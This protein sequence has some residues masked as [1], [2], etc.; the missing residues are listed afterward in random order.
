[1]ARLFLKGIDL[2]NQRAV[3]LADG[4][5]ATDAVT[6][7]QLQAMVRGLSWKDEVKGASTTNLTVASALVNGLVHDGVTYATG[8]SILLKDQTSHAEDGIYVIVASGAASRR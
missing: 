4:T 7:Q 5:A 8:D 2:N 1:M 6:L 3:N